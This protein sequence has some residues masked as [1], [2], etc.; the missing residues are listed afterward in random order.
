MPEKSEILRKRGFSEYD[1]ATNL[2]YYNKRWDI[3]TISKNQV[4]SFTDPQDL[5]AL[6]YKGSVANSGI[7]AT[8]IGRDFD[9]FANDYTPFDVAPSELDPY[10]ARICRAVNDIGAKTC[11]SCDGW[12]RCD[13]ISP[14]MKLYMKDR[15]S[16]IWMWLITEYIFGER[17]CHS[18]HSK[19]S[20]INIWEAFDYESTPLGK[21]RRDMLECRYSAR[22]KNEALALFEKNN[23]YAEFLE[24]YIGEFLTLRRNMVN[25]LYERIDSG[26]I[27][28]IDDVNFMKARKYMYEA[29]ALYSDYLTDTFAE[30]Y[31]HI[32]KINEELYKNP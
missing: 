3:T 31:P 19:K 2:R 1:I 28:N 25:T 24:K 7:C 17:W 4:M 9:S 26:V 5:M 8:Y 11:M 20:F 32:L 6:F 22:N 23:C 10:I 18:D 15:Y 12:H 14:S 30:E 13:D 16:V 21:D 29:F 27:Q